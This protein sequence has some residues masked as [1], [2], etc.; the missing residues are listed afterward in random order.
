MNV[1]FLTEEKPKISVL[2]TL[3][4]TYCKL[5]KSDYEVV[6]ERYLKPIY[7]EKKFT[8]DYELVG[9]KVENI[10]SLYISIVSGSSSFTDYLVFKQESKPTEFSQKNN[11]VFAVEETKTSDKESR[12]TGVFQRASKFVFI[13]SY[14]DV[15]LYM[16]Y[17]DELKNDES[18]KP[19]DTSIFGTN[20]L[21]TL[22]VNIIGKELS[23]WF[24]P[25]TNIEEMVSFKNNM[26]RPPAGNTP[27][28]ITQDNDTMFVSGKLDKRS[29]LGKIS[30]D[31]NIG[32]LSLISATLRTLG[33][34][35]NIVITDHNISQKYIERTNGKNKFLFI[36]K[37][38]GLS[39]KGL[40]LPI[41][42]IKPADYWHYERKSEKVASI[43][44]HIVS[45]NHGYEEVYQNHAGCERGYFKT[46]K[47]SLIA[48][49]KKATNGQNLL[50][51]DLIIRDDFNKKII[52]IEGKKLSTQAIGLIQVETYEDI[53]NEYI[54]VFYPAY[55][56][57]WGLTIFGGE[58]KAI[59]NKKVFL[60]INETGEVFID[61]KLKHLLEY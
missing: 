40:Q 7:K 36:C 35:K 16:L 1:Y 8:F 38:L 10:N 58:L 12:N 52:I 33:W 18:R 47:K 48:L 29:S 22:G 14:Y 5:E 13:K 50:I 4:S 25:F 24:K 15:P 37:Q 27:I 44:F 54:K 53:I 3:I 19:S 32:A 6:S 49:P 31:P 9:L 41:E 61:E 55:D 30:H 60:H 23:K 28:L 17:N 21:L 34:T 46:N 39:M 11:L 56:I 26:R 51:P 43:F 42:Y 20:C 57:T 59:D 2:E 45:E